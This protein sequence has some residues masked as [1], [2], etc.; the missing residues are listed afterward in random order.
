M[1]LIA[2]LAIAAVGA[3]SCQRRIRPCH[4]G[5]DRSSDGSVLALAPKSVHLRFNE[6]VT[7]AVVRVID[8]AG[9]PRGDVT[10]RVAGDTITVTL[11]DN[12][13]RGTQVVSYRVTS[14]DGHPVAGSLVFRSAPRPR[15]VAGASS[16]SSV[17]G[18]IWLARI[19]VYLGLLSA[20]A[21]HFSSA[22]LRRAR[23]LAADHRRARDRPGQRGCGARAAGARSAGFAAAGL[24][25]AAPWKA[26][27]AT[28][29]SSPADR[30]GG[31]DGRH[32]GAVGHDPEYRQDAV[33]ARTGRRRSVARLERHAATAA[34]QWLTRPPCSC[35]AWAQ[36][37]G[38]RARAAG[39][40]GVA[41][42]ATLLPVLRRF[43]YAALVVVAML[44]LTG[45][46]LAI[47]QLG[48]FAALVDSQYG[49]ILSIKLA[50]VAT[51]L[52]WRR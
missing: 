20:S 52:G 21:A 29:C 8:A 45:L 43:S 31:D 2:G 32:R 27:A 46:A 42:G 1:R 4:A 26:A 15:A 18:L 3:L 6:A 17:N 36:P 11:P 50:L 35:M 19:G 7:P 13:P 44:V 10:V 41:A 9:T 51:L 38:R 23:G 37:S 12:L 39:G 14:E 28:S 49:L 47:V 16:G 40:D 48:S 25:T 22:G 24:L 30:D 33:G 5:V 34:P